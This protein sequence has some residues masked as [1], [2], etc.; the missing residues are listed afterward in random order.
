MYSTSLIDLAQNLQKICIAKD[1]K[2]TVAESCTG[3]LIGGLIT[4]IAGSSEIFERGFITYTN[5]AKGELLGVPA[6][7]FMVQGAVSEECATAMAEGALEKA[8]ADLSV[9]VTGIA[10]PSGATDTKPV[11]LV[12]MSV[13]RKGMKTYSERYEFKGDRTAVREQALENAM[14][15]LNKM[16]DF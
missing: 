9:S 14:K 5:Q 3:G 7:I 8:E 13:A 1:L 10:G 4:S 6:H 12:H 2:V 11:G 15:L 16:A